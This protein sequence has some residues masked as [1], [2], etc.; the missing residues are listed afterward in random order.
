MTSVQITTPAGVADGTVE[1]PGDIFDVTA[2]MPLMHQ[3]VVAQLA[4]ARQGTHKTKRRGDS[5][6]PV[7]VQADPT[8][9]PLD[10]DGLG[11]AG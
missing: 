1:L 4:A 6:A 8:R 2:N 11:A 9:I 10:A 3:V 5:R 7:L